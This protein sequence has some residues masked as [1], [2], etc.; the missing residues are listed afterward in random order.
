M[1]DGTS[2]TG[3]LRTSGSYDDKHTCTVALSNGIALRKIIGTCHDGSYLG[4]V[5]PSI[6]KKAVLEGIDR[7]EAIK[8]AMV[9]VAL[10]QGET[11]QI[12]IFS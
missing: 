7:M 4:K 1:Q 8:P 2:K 3:S 11:A 5:S 12:F 9:Q 10:R 6:A